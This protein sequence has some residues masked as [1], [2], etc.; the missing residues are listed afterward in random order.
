MWYERADILR[1]VQIKDLPAAL[2]IS[3]NITITT[4]CLIF[5]SR[6]GYKQYLIY[7]GGVMKV[8]RWTGVGA[9]ADDLWKDNDCFS[10]QGIVRI[11][12]QGAPSNP[13]PWLKCSCSCVLNL[14][15]PDLES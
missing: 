11:L 2:Q 10:S 6:V 12:L 13:Q 3:G 4:E 8:M 1:P 7:R 15:M 9:V 14:L 5:V